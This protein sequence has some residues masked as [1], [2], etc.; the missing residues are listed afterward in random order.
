MQVAAEAAQSCTHLKIDI[1][2]R[3]A[4]AFVSVLIGRGSRADQLQAQMCGCQ[5]KCQWQEAAGN[6]VAPGKGSDSC[7]KALNARAAYEVRT[8]FSGSAHS[9]HQFVLS[10]VGLQAI[11]LKATD[12]S[13]RL[14]GFSLSM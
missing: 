7:R 6:K 11:Y 1:Q 8:T 2:C 13:A 3:Q 12:K 9:Q 5:C 14:L 10:L 4:D